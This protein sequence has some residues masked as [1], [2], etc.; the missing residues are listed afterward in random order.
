MADPPARLGVE[1]RDAEPAAGSLLDRC[2]QTFRV[3]ARPRRKR[4]KRCAG[5]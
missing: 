5:N 4:Q 3:V 1:R 2:D